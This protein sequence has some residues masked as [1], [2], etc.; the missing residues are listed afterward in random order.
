[1]CD[2]TCHIYFN[3][4]FITSSTL[5]LLFYCISNNCDISLYLL[6]I[7]IF[8]QW[9]YL[10]SNMLFSQVVFASITQ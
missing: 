3:N 5:L 8:F 4:T 6:A 9:S 1:M 10:E 7:F 2:S